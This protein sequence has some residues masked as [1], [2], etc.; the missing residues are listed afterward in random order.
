MKIHFTISILI[1]CTFGAI[2]QSPCA[3]DQLLQLQIDS[4]QVDNAVH[5]AHA[6]SVNFWRSQNPGSHALSSYPYGVPLTGGSG[7]TEVNYL[8]PVV[9]HVVHHPSKSVGQDENITM[10]QIEN[11]LD[12]LNK[13]F[14]NDHGQS[15]N[16]GIQFVLARIDQDGNAFSG[17]VRHSSS[18]FYKVSLHTDSFDLVRQAYNYDEK[19]YLNIYI[20]NEILD[21]TLAS[22]A[23]AGYSSY[24]HTIGQEAQGIVMEYDK[25][26]D[27]AA[28][29]SP[30]VSGSKGITLVHEVGHFLGLYHPWRQACN[31]ST[32]PNCQTQG[33]L[34]CDVA[35][36]LNE[37]VFNCTAVN[38]C[39]DSSD[40]DAIY[41]YMSYTHET[42]RSQFTED[43]LSIML[44][45]LTYE[46][47]LLSHP[48]NVNAMKAD[49][50]FWTARFVGSLILCTADTADYHAYDFGSSI[51]YSWQYIHKTTGG[52]GTYSG[53]AHWRLYGLP[54]GTY[55]LELTISDGT[56][57]K[58]W[59]MPNEL[60]VE[61]CKPL[62]STMANWLFGD[63]AGLHFMENDKVIRTT[64]PR[65]KFP[66]IQSYEGS[67]A[68]SDS[69]GNLLFYCGGQDLVNTER[70]G[71]R[72]FGKNYR[73]V[74]SDSID[75][76]GSSAQLGVIIPFNADSS[77]YHLINRGIP[78]NVA[79]NPFNLF[80]RNVVDIT[81]INTS[82]EEYGKV[83]QKNK[84]ILNDSNRIPRNSES[85][86]AI[87]RCNDSTYWLV[88]ADQVDSAVEFYV[89]SDTGAYFSHRQKVAIRLD[90]GAGFIKFSPDGNWL[91]IFN[92]L[93]RFCRLDGSIELVMGDDTELFGSVYGAEFSPNS[94]LFYLMRRSAA[95]TEEMLQFDLMST[96]IY[97]SQI[98]VA[99]LNDLQQNYNYFRN[100]QLA[101]NDKIYVS[102]LKQ[103]Y[104]GVVDK[105]NN[106]VKNN[107]EC[108]FRTIGEILTVAGD[109]GTSQ[110]GLPNFPNVSDPKEKGSFFSIR[111]VS[112][113]T[114]NFIPKTCCASNYKW[115]FGDGDTSLDASPVHTYDS[116]GNYTVKLVIGTDTIK[117]IVQVGLNKETKISGREVICDTS[118][119]YTYS[120]TSN[121]VYSYTWNVV[122]GTLGITGLN[123]ERTVRWDTS[124]YIQVIVADNSGCLD[125]AKLFV[126]KRNDIG[127]DFSVTSKNCSRFDFK[128][129]NYCDVP[130]EWSFGD[131]NTSNEQNPSHTYFAAGTKTVKLKVG[132][133]SVIKLFEAGFS[134]N[135]LS[136]TGIFNNCDD[137]TVFTY[138]MPFHSHYTYQWS[139]TGTSS[140]IDSA[141]TAKAVW[142]TT[143]NIKAVVTNTTLGCVDSLTT[144][145]KKDRPDSIDFTYSVTNCLDVQ[146]E[147]QFYC[148]LPKLWKF[149]DGTTS[150]DQSPNHQYSSRGIFEVKL[151][152]GGDSIAKLI[153]LRNDTLPTING[154]TIICDTTVQYI[155]TLDTFDYTNT[156]MWWSPQGI[157][158][159]D[160]SS[161]A[162]FK[163]SQ[164]GQIYVSM[165][166]EIGCKD[167]TSKSVAVNGYLTQNI[168][169]GD[170]RYCKA[171]SSAKISGTVPTG[172]TGTYTYQWYISKDRSDFT[173]ISGA[174]GKDLFLPDS[175]FGGNYYLR[176]VQSSDCQSS[177]N[178][179]YVAYVMNKNEISLIDTPCII[180]QQA[181][182]QCGFYNPTRPTHNQAVYYT[183]RTSTDGFSWQTESTNY[184]GNAHSLETV[185]QKSLSV[186][187][188]ELYVYRNVQFDSLPIYPVG[189]GCNTNSN[190]I[191][192]K[193]L[194][195]IVDQPEDYFLCDPE[196][197]N[198]TYDI[199]V[200][201][202][203]NS[204]LT[205][206]GEYKSQGASTFTNLGQGT[207]F[208][209]QANLPAGYMGVD[210][211]RFKIVAACGTY[212]SRKALLKI[213]Q[214]IPVNAN[215]AMPYNKTCSIGAS[216]S[217]GASS[218]TSDA[219]FQWEIKKYLSSSFEVITG[220][221]GATLNY[222][223]N[224]ICD[225]SIEFR[226]RIFNGCGSIHTRSAN[227]RVTGI[228]DIWMRDS[229]EDTGLEPNPYSGHYD[230]VLSPDLWNRQDDST[231]FTPE[232]PEYKYLSPNYVRVR[233]RNRSTIDS[234]A[235]LP[236][237]LYWTFASTNGE[238]WKTAWQDVPANRYYNPYFQMSFPM[239]NSINTSP[240][241]IPSI[242]PLDSVII[243]YPWWP[244][245]PIWYQKLNQPAPEAINV[246]LLARIEEC[247]EYPHKM[248]FNEKF[249]TNVIYNVIQNNNIVTRNLWV[250]DEV[251][252][253]E[254]YDGERIR[255]PWHTIG[256]Y[257]PPDSVTTE[258]DNYSFTPC[259]EA[260]SPS[261]FDYWKVYLIADDYLRE[262]IVPV[263]P[264]NPQI[265]YLGNNTFLF[266]DSIPCIAG[267]SFPDPQAAFFAL[268]FEP[269]VDQELIPMELFEMGLAQYA[270]QHQDA[271]GACV[272]QID[273]RT[274]IL[275]PEPPTVMPDPEKENKSTIEW[276]P[277]PNPAETHVEVVFTLKSKRFVEIEVYD[278][279]GRRMTLTPRK[280]YD[281]GKNAIRFD[282]VDWPTGM[283]L[284][285]FK[286]DHYSE[287]KRFIISRD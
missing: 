190:V 158:A 233:I 41:N 186:N 10:A 34:C 212:Y 262:A 265:T 193:P 19:R 224:N 145:V 2:A 178:V 167:T 168:V 70:N 1:Y 165:E 131:G 115:L 80:T 157:K 199:D 175:M 6:A 107:N 72:V 3:S 144:P 205:I 64:G 93:Y 61:D 46:R 226:C 184:P 264:Q 201:N 174:T 114:K 172:G 29:G 286:Y 116:A 27:Y 63:H 78:F 245:R 217:F 44:S 277:Q 20:V 25:F 111:N 112:C 16:T 128:T 118:M 69:L 140:F 284:V 109:G 21:A 180:G 271:I 83:I 177:S 282:L 276:L 210:T 241:I 50:C 59:Q 275:L 119:T 122:G 151:Y 149:G 191:F 138:S 197:D 170:I 250:Y 181:T 54:T 38:T 28:I 104:V 235:A 120:T 189:M 209:Q 171:D 187:S 76:S 103:P 147:T 185:Y 23:V 154:V 88:T 220:Q 53:G 125:T 218:N 162:S 91:W 130:W 214:A 133:D 142:A 278:A 159:G 176:R 146:F 182:F 160:A 227:L 82:F 36:S 35:Q 263:L 280:W 66:N 71:L 79:N 77:K 143:G 85:I 281:K 150:S 123:E 134:L 156:Y 236:L 266:N 15:I 198:W 121:K 9:V 101:P 273:N 74:T 102:A 65:E 60:K 256:G 137:T 179:H 87:K 221:T 247:S 17:I 166:N 252:G 208:T 260:I 32:Y 213:S 161:Y 124:G 287:A 203:G 285:H 259:L 255:S 216:C 188:D 90:A 254:A 135:D 5:A 279:L 231:G 92:S 183:W 195:K 73:P 56:W 239:G 272:F 99:K 219:Q 8:I 242:A 249:D 40:Y 223:P 152:V 243:S 37:L 139:A 229:D 52:T 269:K 24:P 97:A 95:A 31:G 274:G 234:T 42:C 110:V 258:E 106:R 81:L 253:N 155:F 75:G 51:S 127:L 47:A 232:N 270:N 18:R 261:F 206:Y 230:I 251:P 153:R 30:L 55:N 49:G 136:I 98:Q 105:P 267:L 207:S 240:I 86:T 84:P 202:Q 228:A 194:T 200:E 48:A 117:L 215:T 67:T 248:T 22:T 14:R 94:Q 211:F 222:T 164:N 113:L 108:D 68:I 100:L 132:S 129:L 192:I 62:K 244:P 4:G 163:F 89:L 246:C 43:Q 45:K 7:C 148:G 257:L 11:Q 173:Q 58:T 196:T 26:G 225:D 204:S 126:Y 13:A 238:I 57:T 39:V 237:Y 12:V 268:E 169:S 96:D 33:D 141:N 283:Y